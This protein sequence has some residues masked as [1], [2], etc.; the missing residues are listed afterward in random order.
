MEHE[1]PRTHIQRRLLLNK[2][3]ETLERELG[4]M[5]WWPAETPFEV[6]IGAILTQNA[7]W[8]GVMRSLKNMKDAGMFGVDEILDADERA[9]AEAIRPSIYYNQKARRLKAFCMFLA[10]EFAGRIENLGS[11]ELHTARK[12]L[13]DLPGIGCE[14]A[15]SILLYALGRPVFVVDAYTARIFGRHGLV[16]GYI[17]YEDLR[18]Y[19][20]NVLDPDPAIYNEFH[21]LICRVGAEFCKKT[22]RCGSCPAFQI[23]GE[24]V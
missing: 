24:P 23:L 8:T 11:V 10:N 21:A 14:T 22:P 5:R 1:F 6:A 20:E 19:F 9:L 13:L 16:D 3:Y 12:R 4:P 2:L 7:P 17:G 18:M 15:D